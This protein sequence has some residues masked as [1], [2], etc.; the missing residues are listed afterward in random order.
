MEEHTNQNEPLAFD[1]SSSVTV[2]VSAIEMRELTF[3][4]GVGEHSTRRMATM[5]C[6][7]ELVRNLPNG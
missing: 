7:S 6:E 2:V 3:P 5:V 4:F 1:G